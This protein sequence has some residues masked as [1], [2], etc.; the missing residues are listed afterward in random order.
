MTYSQNQEQNKDMYSHHSIQY[1]TRYSS[2]WNQARKRKRNHPERK[3]YKSI[4]FSNNMII[5]MEN[6]MKYTQKKLTRRN[7]WVNQE[8]FRV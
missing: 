2:P 3:K 4:F 1:F 6:L 5:Y 8:G 7:K